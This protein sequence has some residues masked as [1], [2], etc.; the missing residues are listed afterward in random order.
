MM[1]MTGT[2]VTAAMFLAVE[3]PACLG[4]HDHAGG[5]R[6]TLEL[7]GWPERQVTRPGHEQRGAV[8][9]RTVVHDEAA[10]LCGVAEDQPRDDWSLSVGAEDRGQ[11]PDG[12]ALS[13]SEVQAGA[14]VRTG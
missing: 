8:L 13:E 9:R 1:A 5:G 11:H 3:C 2:P 6:E 10:G 7:E 12:R 14:P 4:D